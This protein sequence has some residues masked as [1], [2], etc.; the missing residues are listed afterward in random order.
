MSDVGEPVRVRGTERDAER[1]ESVTAAPAHP[2]SLKLLPVPEHPIQ[3]DQNQRHQR[4]NEQQK[5]H[6]REHGPSP[7]EWSVGDI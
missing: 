7:S 1:E 3:P 4:R 6:K 5:Q 2:G